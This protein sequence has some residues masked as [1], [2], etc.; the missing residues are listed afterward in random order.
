MEVDDL[1]ANRQAQ[2]GSA[3]ACAGQTRLYKFFKNGFA[4]VFGYP[5]ALIAD[6]DA[7]RFVCALEAQRDLAA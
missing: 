5:N 3:S 2:S 1:A 7:G 4:F 6:R